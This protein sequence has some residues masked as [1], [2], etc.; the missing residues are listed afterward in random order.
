[1]EHARVLI[2]ESLDNPALLELIG[3]NDDLLAAGVDSGEMIR[4]AFG[5]EKRLGRR[6]SDAELTALTSVA[7]IATILKAG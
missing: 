2:K 1:M 3:D 4:I 6:L 7:A 5:C